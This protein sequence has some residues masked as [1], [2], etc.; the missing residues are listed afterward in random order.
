MD[1]ATIPPS[2]GPPPPAPAG[3]PPRRVPYLL[4]GVT[5]VLLA[6]AVVVRLQLDRGDEASA[7]PDRLG[8]RGTELPAPQPRPRF[9]LTTTDGRPFD[10]AAETR[11]RLTLLF[12]GYTSCP[13]VCPIHLATLADAL[14]EVSA[15]PLV[16]FVGVD[17]HRDTPTAVREYLDR[18][19]TDFIGL[20]GT[21]EE[22]EAAQR[23][24]EVPVAVSERVEG[25]DD[26]LVGHASQILAYTADDLAHVVYPFG[27]RRQDWVHD[28]PRLAAVGP[29]ATP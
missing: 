3:P 16:V 2:H 22:L 11:G 26:Y 6:V 19:D 9:T 10:F 14:D 29:G 1:P 25:V 5:T 21:S 8:L 24:A 12:F 17:P 4:I 15:E 20:V 28:L 7:A 13:D 27:V 23:A 18:Y